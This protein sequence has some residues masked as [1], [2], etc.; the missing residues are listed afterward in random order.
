MRGPLTLF[1]LLAFFLTLEILPGPSLAHATPDLLG[2]VIVV[3]GGA[4]LF[5]M[6][7]LLA[8]FG[9]QKI[10]RIALSTDK[11]TVKWRLLCIAFL[12]GILILLSLRASYW[13]VA[14]DRL[15]GFLSQVSD[16][17][18]IWYFQY[19]PQ[20]F[21]AAVMVTIPLCFCATLIPHML[22]LR[23][24]DKGPLLSRWKL[25]RTACLMSIIAPL[26]CTIIAL[27]WLGNFSSQKQLGARR[28]G[29]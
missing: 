26:A 3:G 13:L 14:D 21:L 22:F 11:I 7:L 17:L 15:L 1:R 10:A 23:A 24:T 9:K 4:A 27:P 20:S 5:F 19:I 6:P 25:F 12:E 29:N 28:T 2:S 18:A 16:T 8:A